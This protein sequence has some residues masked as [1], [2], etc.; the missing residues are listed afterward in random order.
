MN[1]RGQAPAI[2][3]TIAF[4]AGLMLLFG[5]LKVCLWLTQRLVRRQQGYDCT[6]VTATGQFRPIPW[7]SWD[8][9]APMLWDGPSKKLDM[10]SNGVVMDA[11]AVCPPA[12]IWNPMALD[13]S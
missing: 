10:F 9:P 5:G 3:S 7:E 13:G 8:P 12:T 4:I 2:E 11:K 6:R 1:R